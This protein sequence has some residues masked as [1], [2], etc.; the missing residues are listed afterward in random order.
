MWPLVV[1]A[2]LA[3]PSAS[4]AEDRQ[5]IMLTAVNFW[6]TLDPVSGITTCLTH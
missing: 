1:T 3:A 2:L 5:D 6:E 4:M